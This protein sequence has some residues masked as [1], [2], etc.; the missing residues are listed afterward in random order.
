[1]LIDIRVHLP[2]PLRPPYNN[3]RDGHGIYCPRREY[4]P[5]HSACKP[6]IH[7][8]LSQ[9]E[10][11][12]LIMSNITAYETQPLPQTT[13]G[14]PVHWRLWSD[15][16]LAEVI[17]PT[18]RFSVYWPAGSHWCQV[19]SRESFND[20]MTAHVLNLSIFAASR[21]IE[22]NDLIWTKYIRAMQLLAQHGGGWPLNL[23]LDPQT[24]CRFRGYLFPRRHQSG[25]QT[26][27]AADAPTRG[28]RPTTRGTDEVEARSSPTQQQLSP[29][30]WIPR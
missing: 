25:N 1:M 27:R 14:Q 17:M 22:E 6:R 4:P 3:T 2:L 9:P 29:Q 10:A 12:R 28:L 5:L 13:R 19:M 18:V 30:S 7:R 11:N 26:P 23:F 16:T 15:E 8:L 21:S 20:P 24:L